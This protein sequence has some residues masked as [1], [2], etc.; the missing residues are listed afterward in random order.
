M[1]SGPSSYISNWAKFR[2]FSSK[3]QEAKFYYVFLF[4]FGFFYFSFFQMGPT[5]FFLKGVKFRMQKVS[6]YFKNSCFC[7]IKMRNG[8]YI[9]DHHKIHF[10]QIYKSP[11]HWSPTFYLV[12]KVEVEFVNVLV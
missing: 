7:I 10:T 11:N 4:C 12:P 3:K 1:V 9:L 8:K 2:K 5:I 6:L